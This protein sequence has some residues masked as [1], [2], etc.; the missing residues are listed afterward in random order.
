MIVH[1]TNALG[2]P[3]RQ[4]DRDWWSLRLAIPTCSEF[5]RIM[6]PK[7]REYSDAARG[8][9]AE[10]L[11][12]EILGRPL[13]WGD[14]GWTQRGKEMEDQARQRYE[15]EKNLDV[16]R[17]AFITDDE[18]T[19]G[20]SPDGLV[21][22]DGILEIKCYGAKHHMACVLGLEEIASPLQV[23]GY[24]RL[25]GRQWVDVLAYNPT[26]PI[27]VQRVWRDD[28]Y[29]H[30]LSSCLDKFK[31]DLAKM[32]EKLRVVMDAGG[33]IEDDGLLAQ[34]AASLG[35]KKASHPD[36]LSPD[37]IVELVELL[38]VAKVRGIFDDA[39]VRAILAD[40]NAGRWDDVRNMRAHAQK[41]IG[42]ELVP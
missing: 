5:G 39:D 6:S 42:L 37:E 14:T 16:E 34:L 31:A 20:G 17:C 36:A 12:E 40:V 23:Q 2:E 33:I 3:I 41:Q 8:Y 4:G 32:R 29:I 21:G 27:R 24:M 30:A 26:L 11:A 10:L 18:H 35:K 7:K 15:L 22:D 13:D 1:A 25:T 19:E 28:D 38:E 9:I